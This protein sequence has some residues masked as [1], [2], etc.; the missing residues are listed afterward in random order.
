MGDPDCVDILRKLVLVGEVAEG[1]LF[2]QVH[3]HGHDFLA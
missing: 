2:L 3:S 1:P